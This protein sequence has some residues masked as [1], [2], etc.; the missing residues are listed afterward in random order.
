MGG[1][2]LRFK[3]I[4]GKI[5]SEEGESKRRRYNAELLRAFGENILR[6][7]LY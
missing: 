5:V 1:E 2:R 7:L 4:L 3:L 6:K